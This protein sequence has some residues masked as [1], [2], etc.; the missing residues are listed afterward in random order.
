VK[1]SASTRPPQGGERGVPI[2]GTR[3]VPFV[4]P[5][6]PANDTDNRNGALLALLDDLAVLVADLC[7]QGR[8]DKIPECEPDSPKTGNPSDGTE[9]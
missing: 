3:A 9:V 5:R 1:R 2:D 7:T 6:A 4:R 8:L